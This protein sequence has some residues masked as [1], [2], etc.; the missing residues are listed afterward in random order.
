MI[1]CCCA[2]GG[3]MGNLNDKLQSFMIG[4]NGADRLSRWSLGAACIALI[5]NM[6]FPNIFCSV[7]SYALL[8]YSMYRVFSKNVAAREEEEQ[9]F[10]DFLDRLKPGSKKR[11]DSGFTTRGNAPKNTTK[12]NTSTKTTI[13][14]E[15][16][17]QSLSVPKGRGKLKVTCPKCNH[18]QIIES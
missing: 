10:D 11:R 7:I 5:I 1:R 13:V 12:S 15:E 8:F 4:R 3:S 17:G 2:K 18:Q 9:K 16:C 14:C 6:W